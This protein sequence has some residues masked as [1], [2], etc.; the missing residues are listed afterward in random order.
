MSDEDRGPVAPKH[1]RPVIR[2]AVLLVLFLGLVLV[3]VLT[4][5]IP[6]LDAGTEEGPQGTEEV[7]SESP[8][9]PAEPVE[10]VE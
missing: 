7:A 10:P 8:D 6:A 1:E 5:L 3:G 9:A 4:V 2:N